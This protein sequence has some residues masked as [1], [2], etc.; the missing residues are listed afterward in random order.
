VAPLPTPEGPD[1]LPA[2]SGADANLRVLPWAGFSAAVSYTFDDSQPSQVEHWEALKATGVRMTFYINTSNDWI[3][4]Y[5]ATWQE[6]V[7]LGHEL[8]NHTVHHCRTSEIGT[9]S[10]GT[11]MNGL[12][13]LAAEIDQ[14]SDYIKSVAGQAGV[15]TFAHPFGDTG[16][17]Q[18]A[19]QRFFLARGVNSGMVAPGEGATPLN[20][21][22]V[23]HMGD[24]TV[25]GGDPVSVFEADIDSAVAS[26][27]WLIYLFHTILPTTNNWYAGESIDAI[28]GSIEHAEDLGTVW[29]DSV[30]N[31]G[32]YWVGQKTLEAVTPTSADGALT[33]TWTLPPHFPGGHSLRVAVDG[34]T[35]SQGAEPLAWDGHGYYEVALD[36]GT[37]TWN[38]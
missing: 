33:W 28:T 3:A 24:P 7:A 30:V 19:S 37:L 11:C 34:G 14:C 18:P 5:D 26:G 35:L 6:A 9:G 31:V 21:P 38:P 13:S 29:L 20:L 2:P 23:A 17:M 1:D 32:A 12:P 22:A 27:R 15:W 36:A 4:G 16:Y 8:G 25:A 10:P